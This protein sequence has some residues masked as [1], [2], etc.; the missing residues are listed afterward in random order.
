MM[1]KQQQI[2]RLTAGVIRGLAK[3][4]SKKLLLTGV[5]ERLLE[6]S[7]FLLERLIFNE[8]RHNLLP[9]NWK[10]CSE[11]RSNTFF[12]DGDGFYVDSTLAG[13]RNYNIAVHNAHMEDCVPGE[14]ISL[15]GDANS[16]VSLVVSCS[17]KNR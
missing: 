2:E 15:L 7:P 3:D 17:G 13:I 1:D 11:G 4:Y 5:V 12:V 8:L 14:R 10:K 16:S 9:R 6:K